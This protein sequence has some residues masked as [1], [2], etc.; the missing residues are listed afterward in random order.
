MGTEFKMFN[1]ARRNPTLG[2]T[3]IL[4]AIGGT[5]SGTI[6]LRTAATLDRQF[7]VIQQRL[8]QE[9]VMMGL[10]GSQLARLQVVP[11]E[12]AAAKQRIIVQ[13]ALINGGVVVVFAVAG[14]FLSGQTL[15]PI[16]QAMDEQKRFVAD[17][18]KTGK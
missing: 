16:K 11:E 15:R 7:A 6:Y 4:I 9:R 10:P 5:L 1:Q 3:I 14:Y 8:R 18:G 13:L 12:I 2:Y 17:A